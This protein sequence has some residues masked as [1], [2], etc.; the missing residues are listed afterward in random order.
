MPNPVM[1]FPFHISLPP[2][3]FIL[4]F[5][6]NGFFASRF[7]FWFLMCMLIFIS[8]L[9][10]VSM[11]HYVLLDLIRNFMYHCLLANFL[12]ATHYRLCIV[13]C[14]ISDFPVH[15]SFLTFLVN[16]LHLLRNFI[17]SYKH[18]NM[19]FQDC[20]FCCSCVNYLSLGPQ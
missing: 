12:F 3:F 11:S 19:I 15:F 17:Y 1:S 9:G 14:E 18:P 10:F 6:M 16:F 8:L 4:D 7:H 5:H 2:I 20:N 13:F